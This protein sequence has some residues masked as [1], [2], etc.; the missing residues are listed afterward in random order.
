[1]KTGPLLAL[2][3]AAAGCATSPNASSRARCDPEIIHAILGETTLL[4]SWE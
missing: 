3:R 2:V 1:M 4:R